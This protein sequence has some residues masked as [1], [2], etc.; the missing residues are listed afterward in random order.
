VALVLRNARV[1]TMDERVPLAGAVAIEGERISWV[2]VED[3]VDAHVRPNDGVLDVGGRT[4]LPGFV[5]AHNHVRLGGSAELELNDAVTLGEILERCRVHLAARPDDEWLEAV[6]WNYGALP[7]GRTPTADD[8][9]EVAG[10]RPAFL[11][12]YDAH[13]AWLNREGMR[14]LGIGRGT[15]DVPW[16]LVELDAGGEPTGF[17]KDYAVR[18]LSAAGQR[19]L[20]SVLPSMAPERKYRSLV[21][22]LDLAISLGITTVVEPQN[23][24]EDVALFLRARE[25]GALRSRL[26]AAMYHPPGTTADEVDAFDELRRR[27]DDDRFRV[28]PIKLYVDDVIEP[29]TAA[30]LEPYAN[31]PE[32]SGDTFWDPEEFAETVTALDARGFDCYTHATGDRGIRTVLDAVERATPANGPRDRRHQIVHVECLHDDDV[33]RFAELG[34][35]AC[36]QP[37]HCAPEIVA[38]W[39]ANVGE[40]RWRNAWRFRSLRDAG[41]TL[42]FSSDWNVAEMDPLVGVYT[43]VT[44]ANLD[45]SDAWVPDETVDVDTALRAYTVGSAWAMRGERD[46]GVLSPGYLADLVVLSG[47]PVDAA[48]TDPARL[49]ATRVDL[50]MVGGEVA[51]QRDQS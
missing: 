40:E 14:R 13:T 37:R 8:L 6:G 49:L 39:R 36:M 31:R 7:G 17:V 26:V 42:A 29:W 20:S 32:T 15:T 46:R 44:R 38:D 45:G 5:D 4:V 18:G 48:E 16:G 41:A 27:H 24:P 47:D 11:L 28:G 25:E 33:P 23:A 21:G 30:M 34:V 22:A 12:S 51:Y 43:A 50:T 2:G 35:V 9:E 1:R 19:A 10:G 3:E